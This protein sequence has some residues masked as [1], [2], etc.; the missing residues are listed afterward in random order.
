MIYLLLFSFRRSHCHWTQSQRGNPFCH[1]CSAFPLVF[2]SPKIF[3]SF[4]GS[5]SVMDGNVLFYCHHQFRN[6]T[7]EMLT[8]F[9]LQAVVWK[10]QME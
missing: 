7:H 5:Q 3:S 6:L 2:V 9:S 8:Y 10:K 4:E 1:K